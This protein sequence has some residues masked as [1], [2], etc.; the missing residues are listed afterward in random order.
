MLSCSI[1][2]TL[3]L[4]AQLYWLKRV[5]NLEEQQ[6][7]A[8]VIKSIRG[9]FSDIEIAHD[10]RMQI[11]QVVNMVDAHTYLVKLDSVPSKDTLQHYLRGEFED[12]DVWADCNVGVFSNSKQTF[13]YKFYLSTAA[14]RYPEIMDMN[15]PVIKKNHDYLLLD[16]PHRSKYIIHEMM[17]WIVGAVLLLLILIGLSISL[18]YLYRQKF[19]NELQKDFV[20]NFTHEFKTP[21]AVMK[22]AG[23]VL[24][25]PGIVNKP[26]RL[27]KYSTVIL[28]QTEHLQQQVER[29]LKTTAGNSNRLVI[30]KEPCQLN[31]LVQ[32]AIDQIEPLIKSKGGNVE[33]ITDENEPVIYADKNHLQLV[34]INLVENALKYCKN[35]PYIII[36]LQN[37]SND[38]Y[39]I[40]VKDN[41]IGIDKR[42][43]KYLFNKFYR[44][45][46]GNVHDVTGFGLGL[47]FVKKVIDAHNGKISINSVPGIGTA[48][49]IQLPKK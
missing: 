33:L 23:E 13:S 8:G 7:N 20:D 2:I 10:P 15:L 26:E 32:T 47:N 17:F 1:I 18:L 35:Q 30:K 40:S 34:I 19:L 3:I 44:V 28:E 16:F 4:L 42:N 45:P 36:H 27:H 38:F 6:F 14:S 41:G 9:L 31:L 24:V 49:K 29:L 48:F 21:L 43:I 39:T 22:I 46:T 25:Q 5:Y 11:N 37:G 12:F